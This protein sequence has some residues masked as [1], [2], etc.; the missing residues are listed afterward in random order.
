MTR[1]YDN[2]QVLD[3][4]NHYI[5][6]KSTGTL[7]ELADKLYVSKRTVQNY[8]EVLRDFK[9]EIEYCPASRSYRYNFRPPFCFK[10]VLRQEDLGKVTGGSNF[11]PEDWAD[12]KYLLSSSLYL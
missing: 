10:L 8:L 4:L 6:T 5:H 1:L 12:A 2:L 9:A 3:R 11:I 7:Q